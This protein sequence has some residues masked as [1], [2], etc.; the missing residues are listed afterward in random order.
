MEGAS[1][2][3]KMYTKQKLLRS[4]KW[5]LKHC[6]LQHRITHLSEASLNVALAAHAQATIGW[7]G[8]RQMAP[9]F[10]F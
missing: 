7:K 4:E 1:E 2:V 6:V 10:F 3:V 5:V 8:P 9:V